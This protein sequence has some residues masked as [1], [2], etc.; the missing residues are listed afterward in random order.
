MNLLFKKYILI[1]ELTKVYF[2]Y[3]L[4]NLYFNKKYKYKKYKL[5]WLI[6]VINLIGFGEYCDNKKV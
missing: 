5:F 4:I 1:V 6:Y 3:I 2:L